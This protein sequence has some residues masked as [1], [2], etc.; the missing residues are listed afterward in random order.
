LGLFKSRVSINTGITKHVMVTQF[1]LNKLLICR[2]CWWDN[3]L[4]WFSKELK[5]TYQRTTGFLVSSLYFSFENQ[6]L[7]G[8]GFLFPIVLVPRYKLSFCHT[9]IKLDLF[10]FLRIGVFV[11]GL[12]DHEVRIT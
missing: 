9:F 4:F 8:M 2:T 11:C 3:L 10:G 5:T 1:R 7:F 6:Y 12:R